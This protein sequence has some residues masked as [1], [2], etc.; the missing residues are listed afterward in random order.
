LWLVVSVTIVFFICA[1]NM[2][3]RYLSGLGVLAYMFVSESG[4]SQL[5]RFAPAELVAPITGFKYVTGVTPLSDW[6]WPTVLLVGYLATMGMLYSYMQGKK[7]LDLYYLR[8]SHNLFLSFGSFIMLVGVIRAMF[9]V[10][11][12]G[13]LDAMLCDEPRLQL[14]GSLYFWYYIFYMSKFYEFIDTAILIFRKKQVSFLHVFHHVTT[15]M[16]SWLG[17]YSENAMQWPVIILN[18]T[19]HVFMYYY[20]LVQT[21]GGDVWWKKYLT[22]GQIA[23]FITDLLALAVWF[24]YKLYLKRDCSGDPLALAFGTAVLFSFLLL[25][26]NFYVRT[27]RAAKKERDAKRAKKEE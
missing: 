23:Q 2:Q 17:L 1:G 11:Q 25:F 12:K 20:Y 3:K 14:K 15:V 18:T 16:I 6:Q 9:V 7:A 10:F 22:T 4:Q 24:W 5:Q 21:L 27:Y 19:V 8:V 26:I 13:G